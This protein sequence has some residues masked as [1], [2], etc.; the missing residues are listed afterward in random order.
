MTRDE[1]RTHV[2]EKVIYSTYPGEAEGGVITAVGDVFIYVRYL[3]EVT[4][5]ATIPECLTL[6]RGGSIMEHFRLNQLDAG[7]PLA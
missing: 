6:M 3:G 4:S 7:I 1:A 5:K 2:G